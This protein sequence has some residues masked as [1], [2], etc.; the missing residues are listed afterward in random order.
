MWLENLPAV[1]LSLSPL[2]LSRIY[3]LPGNSTTR[4]GDEKKTQMSPQGST[5][6][7]GLGT[8][9]SLVVKQSWSWALTGVSTTNG[10]SVWVLAIYLCWD[11]IMSCCSCWPSTPPWME[12]RV[13][14]SSEE[15]CSGKKWQPRFSGGQT[16]SGA[17]FM[18]PILVSP[19]I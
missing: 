17:N 12:F 3:L 15:L 2:P 5:V 11:Y 19:H 9:D 4:S 16:Y 6:H 18:S 10:H 7:S 8:R 14:S 1:F 13:E